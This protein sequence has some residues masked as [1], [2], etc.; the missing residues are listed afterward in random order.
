MNDVKVH[1]FSRY[2]PRGNGSLITV[3]WDEDFDSRILWWLDSLLPAVAKQLLAA[4]EHEGTLTLWWRGDSFVGD[5]V[6]T[7]DGDIW[8]VIDEYKHCREGVES[9]LQRSQYDCVS[10]IV[11]TAPTNLN[12]AQHE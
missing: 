7:P 2:L 8:A 9:L 6:E 5:N 1:S 3:F 10:N 12:G 4:Y 11:R